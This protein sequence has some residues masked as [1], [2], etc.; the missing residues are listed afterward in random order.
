MVND[1]FGPNNP[2]NI[3][4]EHFDEECDTIWK[5]TWL[6]I[7]KGRKIRRTDYFKDEKSAIEFVDSKLKFGHELINIKMCKL[8][9]D[10]GQ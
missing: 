6:H 2:L 3:A 9:D 5:A 1:L 10:N 4:F 7:H 8:S